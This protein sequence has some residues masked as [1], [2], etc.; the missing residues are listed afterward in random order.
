MEY[1]VLCTMIVFYFRLDN[2]AYLKADYQQENAKAYF[3]V[4]L[5]EIKGAEGY[6]DEYP[7]VF[8]GN[9]DGMDWSIRT[10]LEFNEIQLQGYH[11]NMNQFISYFADVKFLVQHCGYSYSQPSD[12]QKIY[13]S[14][15]I[16]NMPCYP[17]DGAVQVVDEVVV[18]KF[19]NAY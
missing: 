18:V 3:T 9:L 10:P 2:L 11:T 17:D 1:V 15:Y 13:E 7:V 16:R 14:E 12:M 8:L 4:L 6:S 19:S 5:S